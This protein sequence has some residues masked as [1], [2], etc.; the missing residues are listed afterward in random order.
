M[1]KYDILIIGA[2]MVGLTLALAIRKLSS[3]TVAIADT[4]TPD[5]LTAQP[6]LRVSAINGASQTIFENLNV[7]QAIEQ[8]RSQ[9][10]QH[11]HIW[12]KAGYGK[13]AFSAD[14]LSAQPSSQSAHSTYSTPSGKQL[15][16]IVENKVIRNTLWQQAQQDSGISFYTQEAISNIGMGDSEVFASFTSQMPITAK[17]V[18][19]ADGANSWLRNQLKM[20]MTF[21]DYDHHA[22]VATVACSQGHH[23][24][25]WQ[26]FLPTGPL[27]FLPLSSTPQSQANEKGNP[28]EQ[29]ASIVWSCEPNEAKRLMNLADDDFNKEITA[30][31]DGKLGVVRIVS[32][33]VS[34]PLTM[35]L[36]Q[37]FIQERAILI[38]D[39]AHTIHPLAGQGV[40]LGLKDAAALAESLAAQ[41]QPTQTRSQ[42]FDIDQKALKAFERW[43]KNDAAEMIAAM[44]AIKQVFTPQQKPTQIIRG[45]GMSLLNKL[46]PVKQQMIKQALGYQ[47]HLPQLAKKLN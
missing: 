29:L 38:G 11:M 6:E 37:N 28:A 47:K 14:Q 45:I 25:A 16:Y 43:R 19:G 31:A 41:A 30:A 4:Q 10:Y 42:G 5:E 40:N 34:Y 21:R 27:A 22:I 9:A 3:L 32:N 13:L 35:R 26:V 18:V 17:L 33:K 15:G 46:A 24:T 36:A 1:K 7:W 23:N 44:E 12:D 39:A 2:G 20:A 8:T